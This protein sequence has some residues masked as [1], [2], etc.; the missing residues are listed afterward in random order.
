L[1]IVA[2][3][4]ALDQWNICRQTHSIDVITSGLIVQSIQNQ[5]ELL[6]KVDSIMGCCDAIVVSLNL[7]IRIETQ[8]TLASNICLGLADVFFVEQKLS[9][10][11]A[12]IDSIQID[13]QKQK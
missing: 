2:G 11:V 3:C 12:D 5:I 9:V 7:H 10:Q 6:E 13:L 4:S 1:T 8:R